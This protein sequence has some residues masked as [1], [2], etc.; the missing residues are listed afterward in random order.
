MHY[1]QIVL[2][3]TIGVLCFIQFKLRGESVPSGF[4]L[5]YLCT[6][7]FL[8]FALSFLSYTFHPLVTIT[9]DVFMVF[10]VVFHTLKYLNQIREQFSI[11]GDN[12]YFYFT[13][14]IWCTFGFCAILEIRNTALPIKRRY[15]T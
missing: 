8:F 6:I 11:M 1:F 7:T 4:F 10:Y 2:I 13:I 15:S 9:F 5:N 3:M 14:F 12:I